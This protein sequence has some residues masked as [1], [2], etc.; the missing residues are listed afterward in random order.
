MA[1]RH[2]PKGQGQGQD[3]PTHRLKPEGKGGWRHGELAQSREA[4]IKKQAAPEGRRRGSTTQEVAADDKV[5]RWHAHSLP[6][7]RL[8]TRR[9]CDLCREGD[10]GWLHAVIFAPV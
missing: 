5:E 2:D 7:L 6:C 1:Q 9:L 8:T 3:W 10:G 4:G